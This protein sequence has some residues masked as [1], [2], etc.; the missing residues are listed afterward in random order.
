MNYLFDAFYYDFAF[1]DYFGG[2][3]VFDQAKAEI[4]QEL[5]AK[6]SLTCK[7]LQEILVK[8]LTFIKDGH[9]NINQNFPAEKDI[10]FFFRQ[11]MFVK[12]DS[13]YQDSKGKTVVS[14]D[15]YPDLDALFKRSISKEGYLVYY[16]V[17]LKEAKFD[18]T[19]WD[20]H[21]CDEQ[22][23]VHYADGST[24]VLTADTWSQY[25]KDL[26]KGRIPT[27]ARPTGFRCSSLTILTR[28]S[29]RRPMPQ[30]RR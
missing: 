16:P 22:L 6:D 11:V 20:K 8:H 25:Y 14:V 28:P 24:D 3:T 12:T 10:P 9:F 29:W 23:T 13:G 21:V 5:Q 4:L 26:P 27:C 7:D 15:G 19:E 30:Q 1:Y 2:H 18:G 17:L